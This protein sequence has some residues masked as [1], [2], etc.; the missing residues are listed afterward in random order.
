MLFRTKSNLGTSAL[1]FCLGSL[2]LL[3][4]NRQPTL[5]SVYS[6]V[7][8]SKVEKVQELSWIDVQTNFIYVR[9]EW[10]LLKKTTTATAT[11]KSPNTTAVHV[12]C[13]SSR[14]IS[15]PSSAQEHRE[16]TKFCV[17]WRTLATTANF[18]YFLLEL[19][20]GV[21]SLVWV[22]F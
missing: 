17:F 12:R 16:M 9:L 18:S 21:T 20:A 5:V 3:N 15:Q 19:I 1:L 2:P 6:T 8:V 11:R 13:K 4:F 22:G 10:D 14:Y 7:N